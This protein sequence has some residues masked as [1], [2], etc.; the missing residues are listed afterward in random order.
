MVLAHLKRNRCQDM[1]RQSCRVTSSHVYIYI[2]IYS[3]CHHI[4]SV[5]QLDAFKLEQHT[6][7]EREEYNASAATDLT[8]AWDYWQGSCM[9]TVPVDTP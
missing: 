3:I 5:A 2:D 9:C 7:K 8:K 4:S 1:G 6:R